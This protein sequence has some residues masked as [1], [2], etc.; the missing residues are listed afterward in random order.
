MKKL[1]AASIVLASLFIGC[2]TG[3]IK[4][5]VEIRSIEIDLDRTEEVI[6]LSEV[7]EG[8]EYIFLEK[9]NFI[10]S[11]DKIYSH[12]D[13]YYLLDK[14]GQK[15]HVYD[16]YGR[17]IGQLFAQGPGPE[18]YSSIDFAEINRQDGTIDIFDIVGKKIVSYDDEGAF[19][20]SIKAPLISRDFTTTDDGGYLFYCPDEQNLAFGKELQTGVYYLSKDGRKLNLVNPIGG[21]NFSP[22]LTPYSFVRNGPNVDL[23][24]CYS[25]TIFTF[26]NNSVSS[27]LLMMYSEPTNFRLLE[28]PRFTQKLASDNTALLK[29][30]P[31]S[32]NGFLSYVF[33]K[34]GKSYILVK[35]ESEVSIVEKVINDL[36]GGHPLILNSFPKGDDS[37]VAFIA[38]N[39]I[40]TIDEMTGDNLKYL[41]KNNIILDSAKLDRRQKAIDHVLG[42]DRNGDGHPVLIVAKLK[43][44]VSL[45]R[46]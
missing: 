8:I 36:D 46:N 7:V 42:P 37:L 35:K 4:T 27:R 38:E 22:I 34:N 19:V 1:T 30:Y 16:R 44:P 25:D 21:L 18:E 15:V 41:D 32:S 14:K 17:F 2:S 45:D 31:F 6:R 20:R 3:S 10:G 28:D 12:G 33:S 40:L 9:G 29:I 26:D 23:F 13:K 11:L 39:N 5:K 43:A 24:S